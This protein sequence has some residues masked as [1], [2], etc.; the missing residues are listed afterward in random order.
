M[1]TAADLLFFT[2]I[3]PDSEDAAEP[4]GPL[5]R[6]TPHDRL[7]AWHRAALAGEQP[8]TP[9][10]DPQCGWYRRRLVKGAAGVPARIW[11]HQEVDAATG[12]LLDDEELRCEVNGRPE[13]PL[14]QWIWLC[15]DPI[16]EEHYNWMIADRTWALYHAPA[17]PI[18]NPRQRIDWMTVR[19]PEF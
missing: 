9:I 10:S 14:D 7:Y 15:K 17:E 1:I 19:P 2:G 12:E 18:A 13:D 3:L 6:P 11:L 8:F 5:R 4:H 16:S